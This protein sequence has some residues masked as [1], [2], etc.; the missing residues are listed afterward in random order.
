L[1]DLTEAERRLAKACDR[2]AKQRDRPG[3]EHGYL[4]QRLR[5][6]GDRR[7]AAAADLLGAGSVDLDRLASIAADDGPADRAQHVVLRRLRRL[8]V[9]A[10]GLLTDV[11]NELRGAAM[12][13][14]MAAGTK[15]D[16]AR[17]VVD[18]LSRALEHR[19]R[20]PAEADCPT[21]GASGALGG[22]WQQRAR[23]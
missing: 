11:V 16:R 17:G 2:F 15:G 9:P 13:L 12:E 6:S 14:A 20:H 10:R 7:A 1:T 5:A 19:E 22:D 8:S 18:L 23:S 21:C 3:N 4:V